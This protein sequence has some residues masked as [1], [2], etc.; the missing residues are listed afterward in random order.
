MSRHYRHTEETTYYTWKGRQRS[1]GEWADIHG[2]PY[3]AIRWRY[4][5]GNRGE[6]LFRPLR[7]MKSPTR[8]TKPRVITPEDVVSKPLRSWLTGAH[9]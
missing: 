5:A 1:L 2:L 4:L 7:K 9:P 8:G 6:H 3:S